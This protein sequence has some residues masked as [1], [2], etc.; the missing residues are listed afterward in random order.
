MLHQAEI[1]QEK[2]LLLLSKTS[3]KKAGTILNLPNDSI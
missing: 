2:I 1:I 3:M